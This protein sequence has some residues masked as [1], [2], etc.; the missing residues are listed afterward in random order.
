MT[1]TPQSNLVLGLD[2]IVY[3]LDSII[4]G[5]APQP[6][7]ELGRM[8]P[9]T[10]L[11]E[12]ETGKV[13]SILDLLSG[14]KVALTPEQLKGY[15]MSPRSGL[16]E[17]TNGNVVSLIDA[18]TQAGAVI[19]G[20]AWMPVITPQGQLSWKEFEVGDTPPGPVNIKGPAGNKIIIYDT[21]FDTHTTAQIEAFAVHD[22]RESF[23]ITQILF[24]PVSKVGDI[25]G[26]NIQNSDTGYPSLYIGEVAEIT[27]QSLVCLGRGAIHSGVKGEKGDKGVAGPKGDK[28]DKGDPGSAFPKV[29]LMNVEKSG[30]KI[31]LITFIEPNFWNSIKNDFSTIKVVSLSGEFNISE[32]TI[33]SMI[34]EPH[35]CGPEGFMGVVVTTNIISFTYTDQTT[36]FVQN[37]NMISNMAN[38]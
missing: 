19:T 24:S 11:L 16:V 25:I 18:Y 2:G 9:Q 12:D 34:E 4:N 1:I 6:V 14:Q 32:S 26:L 22:H 13:Y 36:Y 5:Q 7:Q 8:S 17:D 15:T 20:K 29:V 28:G 33:E 35:T 21:T 38:I 10:C 27:P 30:D 3:K 37:N 23:D 31:K